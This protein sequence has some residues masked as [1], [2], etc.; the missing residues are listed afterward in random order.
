MPFHPGRAHARSPTGPPFLC[1]TPIRHCHKLLQRHNGAMG[2]NKHTYG[3]H[4]QV[5]QWRAAALQQRLD[6]FKPRVS[7]RGRRKSKAQADEAPAEAATAA[8]GGGDAEGVE[9]AGGSGGAGEEEPG[10]A[11]AGEVQPGSGEEEEWGAGAGAQGEQDGEGAGAQGEQGERGDV[12]GGAGPLG[13]AACLGGEAGGAAGNACSLQGTQEVCMGEASQAAAPQGLQGTQEVAPEAGGSQGRAA[14]ARHCSPP[15]C[16]PGRC[17]PGAQG[18]SPPGPGP[19]ADAAASPG[20]SPHPRLPLTPPRAGTAAEGAAASPAAVP[21]LQLPPRPT[22]P[23]PRSPA[24]AAAPPPACRALHAMAA[25]HEL[26][27]ACD[28]LGAP[29]DPLPPI[30]GPCPPHHHLGPALATPLQPGTAPAFACSDPERPFPRPAPQDTHLAACS[31]RGGGKGGGGGGG[32]AV[33]SVMEGGGGTGLH[34][35]AEE[36]LGGE[37]VGWGSGPPRLEHTRGTSLAQAAGAAVA[38]GLSARLRRRP[39][40]AAPPAAAV[41][42]ADGLSVVECGP[43][44]DEQLCTWRSPLLLAANDALLAT[45]RATCIQ[46]G[47]HGPGVPRARARTHHTHAQA[48]CRAPLPIRRCARIVLTHPPHA[49]CSCTLL[50]RPAPSPCSRALLTRPAPVPHCRAPPLRRTA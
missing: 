49:P 45:S 48:R 47:G 32:L 12:P 33:A 26:L 3:R 6:F 43:T 30:H 38:R 27:S 20:P 16:S 36:A 9:A 37:C 40:G 15:P 22:P 31:G 41:A 18:G 14:G 19:C 4:A 7:N 5:R 28:V 50:T 39:A 46:V 42:A 34:A 21:P 11:G 35:C 23:K 24:P 8:P 10:A 44:A 2:S 17:A 29:R 1:W 25:L 13:G